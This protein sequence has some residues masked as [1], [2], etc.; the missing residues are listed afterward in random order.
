MVSLHRRLPKARRASPAARRRAVLATRGLR[1]P[2]VSVGLSA[3]RAR[4]VGRLATF[5]GSGSQVAPPDPRA[6]VAVR[7]RG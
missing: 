1:Q 5:A 6:V 2:G 3:C 7:V 4:A